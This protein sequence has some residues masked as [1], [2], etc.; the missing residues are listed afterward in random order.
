M[1]PSEIRISRYNAV[2]AAGQAASFYT[3]DSYLSMTMTCSEQPQVPSE[4]C[5][6][7][8]KAIPWLGYAGQLAG[9]IPEYGKFISGGMSGLS[10]LMGKIYSDCQENKL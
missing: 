2:S 1:V 8:G 4:S 5:E 9:A 6:K 3:R 7:Y 10:S